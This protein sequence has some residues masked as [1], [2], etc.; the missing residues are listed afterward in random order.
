MAG[1]ILSKDLG[2][3]SKKEIK[4]LAE[5]RDKEEAIEQFRILGYEVDS[6]DLDAIKLVY[7]RKDEVSNANSLSLEQLE[8]VAGG[9]RSKLKHLIEKQDLDII[10]ENVQTLLNT[11]SDLGNKILGKLGGNIDERGKILAY[12]DVV[13]DAAKETEI[14][15]NLTDEN[16]RN[17]VQAV[18]DVYVECAYGKD[19]I[20]KFELRNNERIVKETIALSKVLV[21][22]KLFVSEEETNYKGVASH[23]AKIIA[24]HYTDNNLLHSYSAFK[25]LTKS[26]AKIY[27][28]DIHVNTVQVP[29]SKLAKEENNIFCSYGTPHGTTYLDVLTPKH[30]ID[31]VDDSEFLFNLMSEHFD[32]YTANNNIKGAVKLTGKGVSDKGLL[33]HFAAAEIDKGKFFFKLRFDMFENMIELTNTAN[34]TAKSNYNAASN[35]TVMEAVYLMERHAT[36][37]QWNSLQSWAGLSTEKQLE[38]AQ[39]I[40]S[41]AAD[42]V[43]DQTHEYMPEEPLKINE[44]TD[45]VNDSDP[46]TTA[47]NTARGLGIATG[48]G[49]FITMAVATVSAAL[50]GSIAILGNCFAVAL[51]ALFKGGI[52]AFVGCFAGNTTMLGLG[53]AF[54]AGTAITA[55]V[56]IAALTAV[57]IWRVM[58]HTATGVSS[59]P[60]IIGASAITNDD[61]APPL[62][63]ENRWIPIAPPTP[64]IGPREDFWDS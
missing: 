54:L 9:A 61:S 18:K 56:G 10:S 2:G 19:N 58:S 64:M 14:N 60:E 30:N 34:T 22:A 5:C 25:D 28:D 17:I 11:H 29:G 42:L 51:P 38:L 55:G 37:Y 44:V 49:A 27:I 3:L 50:N 43:I 15:L 32:K 57:V 45:V 7:E 20:G 16:E 40:N 13:T 33:T 59:V 6:A 48:A 41:H 4:L 39:F 31:R 24:L 63:N 53:A 52:A 36:P 46:L 62:V 47:K 12:V 1:K 21:N 23:A 26:D 8:Q 35:M